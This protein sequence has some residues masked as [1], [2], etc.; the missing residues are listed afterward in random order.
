MSTR[1]HRQG[2]AWAAH[3]RDLAAV[4]GE[5]ELWLIA[6]VR[7]ALVSCIDRLAPVPYAL[8][9][10]DVRV[11]RVPRTMTDPVTPAHAFADDG[12]VACLTCDARRPLQRGICWQCKQHGHWLLVEQ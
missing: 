11:V 2:R 12:Y 8:P 3:R 6:V 10:L 1:H 7:D 9:E 5:Q 4:R